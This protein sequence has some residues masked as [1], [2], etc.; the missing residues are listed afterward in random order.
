MIEKKRLGEMLRESGLLT[1]SQLEKALAGQKKDG[2]KLGQ[3]VIRQSLVSEMQICDL[4]SRQLKIRKYH[5]DQFPID[6]SLARVIPYEL[7]QKYQVAPLMKKGRLL[8]AAMVDPLDINALDSVEAYTNCEVEAVVCTETEL[9]NLHRSIYTVQSGLEGVVEGIASE[10]FAFERAVDQQEDVQVEAIQNMALNTPVVIRL[11]NSIFANA[12]QERA[13]DIHISPQ[14]NGVQVRFRIDGRLHSM[15]AP[16]KSMFPAVVARIKILADMDITQSR[17]PLDGR[18]TLRL[19]H[20]LINVRA[21][22]VPTVNGENLVMRLLDTSTGIF[23]LDRLGMSTSDVT[24]IKSIINKPYGMILSTGPTGS[25]KSSSLYAIL[26]EINEPHSHIITLEDPVEYKLD[27]IRQIQLNVKAGMTF[28]SGL[29]AILRQDPDIIM[30]GEIR[31]SETAAI[32][33]RAAQTGHRLLSTLHTNDSAGAVSRLIDMGIEPFL[34]SSVLLVSFAQRLVRTICP[35]CREPF[36]PPSRALAAWGLDRVKDPVFMH[37]RGCQ[38]CLNTGY[39]GRTGI[40][41]VLVND[42]NIQE[43]ILRKVSAHEIA[44][45]AVSSGRMTTLKQDAADKVA[46]GITTLEEAEATVSL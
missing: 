14:Q 25:G 43:M 27:S 29:R 40:F 6:M 36:T 8:T 31:D 5:P 7:A 13:S 33:V 44:S 10:E 35:Y 16:P 12:I 45:E 34:V 24:K 32:A 3:Y 26:Q 21:S 28:A 23:M 20:K 11:V 38:Q 17:I 46:R 15:P 19:G 41:E 37:G 1:D 4:L 39:K 22:T 42:E 30:V 2:V 9:T 18:F